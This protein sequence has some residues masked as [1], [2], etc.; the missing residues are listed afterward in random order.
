MTWREAF[1]V[2]TAED[3]GVYCLE[4][5]ILFEWV[6]SRG[7]KL[8][9]RQR[10]PVVARHP[11]SGEL[12]WFNQLTFFHT[13]SLDSD[14]YQILERHLKPEEFPHSTVH[15]DGS[16][17]DHGLVRHLRLA[18]QA[19]EAI[20]QWQSGDLLLVDNIRVAYGRKPF[21][22]ERRV[23]V[24][25]GNQCSWSSLTKNWIPPSSNWQ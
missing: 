10:R 11:E 23:L 3:L 13:S 12:V 17:I 18:Y 21:T 14:L 7:S 1:Q 22:G 15:A 9:T 4:N 8:R 2:N 5:D 19:E 25:M 20:F 6:G 16:P 24:C